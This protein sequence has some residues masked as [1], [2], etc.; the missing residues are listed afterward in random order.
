MKIHLIPFSYLA[1]VR[2]DDKTLSGKIIKCSF[3]CLNETKAAAG[4]S[5]RVKWECQ[6][7]AHLSNDLV[8]ACSHCHQAQT[9]RV[10]LNRPLEDLVRCGQAV[11]MSLVPQE[12]FLYQLF[13]K[14][15]WVMYPHSWRLDARKWRCGRCGFLQQ[16]L[17]NIFI[18]FI[19]D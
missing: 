4:R 6:L 9:K 16:L 3:L 11:L 19:V 15:V 18:F 8:A 1:A 14:Y 12:H 10:T 5:Y 7:V 17:Q 2:L 13:S